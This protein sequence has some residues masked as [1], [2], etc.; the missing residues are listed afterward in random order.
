MSHGPVTGFTFMVQGEKHPAYVFTRV[1]SFVES[2]V[3]DV[4]NMTQDMFQKHK[5]SFLTVFEGTLP[6]TLDERFTSFHE[7]IIAQKKDF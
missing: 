4:N 2:F 3:D 1:E 5:D 7:Q 6:S